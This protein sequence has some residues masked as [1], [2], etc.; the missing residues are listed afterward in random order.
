[1]LVEKPYT[2]IP[3][4]VD[5][6]W[7]EAERN[8][9]VLEEAYMWRHSPQTRMLLEL[10][11]QIGDVRAVEVTFTATL[12]REDDP[13]W[14][15]EL[16]GGALLDVGCYCVSAARVLLGEPDEVRGEARLG[17]GGVDERFGG[18]LHFGDAV[19]TFECGLTSPSP[20]VDQIQVVGSNGALRVP[21]AFV[22]PPGVVVL[23]GEKHTVDPGNH[24]RAE[25][26]DVCAAIRGERGVLLGRDEMRGQAL[27][28]DALL[29]SAG[30]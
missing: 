1:V 22:D 19:A 23:N 30:L 5:E 8:G 9:L 13:R 20:L 4:Q 28:L 29:R 16:G 21:N 25:L 26:E 24:Y 27:V 11:P 6:A 18:T 10:L 15:P 3:E 7:D 2:R 14:V 12:S 17:R